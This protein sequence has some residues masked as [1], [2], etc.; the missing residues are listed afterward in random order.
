MERF[1]RKDLRILCIGEGKKKSLSYIRPSCQTRSNAWATS[2]NVPEQIWFFFRGKLSKKRRSNF[3]VYTCVYKILKILVTILLRCPIA[4]LFEKIVFPCDGT[5][6]FYSCLSYER[7]FEK[8]EHRRCVHVVVI[9]THESVTD[10]SR[11]DANDANIKL[12][13][14]NNNRRR[15]AKNVLITVE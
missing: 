13:K 2:R 10:V 8:G 9:R 4:G 12:A 3:E 7:F 5:R 14:T 1:V 11:D 15:F 6:G